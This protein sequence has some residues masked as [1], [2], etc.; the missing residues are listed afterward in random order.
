MTHTNAVP[1]LLVFEGGLTPQV[2][3]LGDCVY[4]VGERDIQ[5][6]VPNCLGKIIYKVNK[7]THKRW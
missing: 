4:E 3:E 1:S 7:M 2:G 6:Q 5:P